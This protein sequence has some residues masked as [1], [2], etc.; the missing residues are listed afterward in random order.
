M[1]NLFDELMVVR[2]LVLSVIRPRR[3]VRLKLADL[4]LAHGHFHWHSLYFFVFE[5]EPESMLRLMPNPPFKPMLMMLDKLFPMWP[6]KQRRPLFMLVWH[7]DPQSVG[8]VLLP[9]MTCSSERMLAFWCVFD[10]WLWTSRPYTIH[11][12]AL[13]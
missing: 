8:A 5:L 10:L 1:L 11:A 6:R 7:R 9:V 13:L 3:H 2:N 12:L 4:P